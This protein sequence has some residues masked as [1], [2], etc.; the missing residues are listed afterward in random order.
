MKPVSV[1]CGYDQVHQCPLADV[2]TSMSTPAS[3]LPEE[4]SP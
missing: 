4:D 2:S 3:L 1:D